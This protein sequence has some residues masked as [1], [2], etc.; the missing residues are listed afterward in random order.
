LARKPVKVITA[1]VYGPDGNEVLAPGTV[2]PY[3]A[4]LPPEASWR[5]DE[6]DVPDP[7]PEPAPL[8]AEEPAPPPPGGRRHVTV[9]AEPAAG[10][11]G[12][13]T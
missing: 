2:L 3:D 9:R 10:K 6:A 4:D 5:L 13:G 8:A 12:S 1:S 11:G 7:Q